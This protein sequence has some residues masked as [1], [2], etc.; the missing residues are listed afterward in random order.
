ML[1]YD[2]AYRLAVV[3]TGRMRS[4]IAMAGCPGRTG[5]CLGNPDRA[6]PLQRDAATLR[7]WQ[8]EALI[9][10]LDE[11]EFAHLRL[12][13]LP[14]LLRRDGI[15]WYHVPVS[16]G[17]M[18][19]AAFEEAWKKAAPELQ[20]ILLRGG[21]LAIHCDDG[22]DRTALVT[23]RA[24]VELG[25]PY[26]DAINRVRGARPGVLQHLDEERYIRNQTPRMWLAEEAQYLRFTPP[27]WMLAG[28]RWHREYFG[29]AA[30]F[31]T[32]DRSEPRLAALG[33]PGPAQ[34]PHSADA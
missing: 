7:H 24:L 4:Q 12:H 14:E 22:R 27:Q 5:T 16:R 9:T 34:R 8:A 19:D 29:P 32:A 26:T 15:A 2:L 25:C 21:R 28:R 11:R 30:N 23:A 1:P 31:P 13:R 17:R 33:A 20:R 10:L 18:P 6:W 3:G